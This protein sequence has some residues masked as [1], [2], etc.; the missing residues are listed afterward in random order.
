VLIALVMGGVGLRIKGLY[1]ALFTLA[2]AEILFLLVGNRIFVG[3]T[4]AEDGFTFDV[5]DWLNSTQNRLFFYYLALLA[6]AASFVVV[7]RLMS[8]PTGRVLSAVRENEARAQMLGYNTLYFKLVALVVA[9]L[10]ASGAGVLR[11]LML[12]GAS[13][14][15]LSLDF[16]ITPLLMTLIGGQGTFIG[17]IVGA[18]GVRLTEQALRDTVLTFGSLQVNVGE[19]W[20]LILGTLFVLSVLVFPQ[21]IV[22]TL[23]HYTSRFRLP[24]VQPPPPKEPDPARESGV[25]P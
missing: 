14:N 4:G 16:T 25:Q 15:V 8:S 9:G 3:T 11:G 17:P 23:R 20:A 7:R 12:K 13:P 1:F 10:M 21:G 19:H 5:P 18:F 6:L 2:L 22:G 24:Q